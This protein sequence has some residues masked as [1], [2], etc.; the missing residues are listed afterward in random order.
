LHGF[1]Y[2]QETTGLTAK[3]KHQIVVIKANIHK[4][5]DSIEWPFIIQC[6]KASGF[7]ER[8]C[9]WIEFLIL[10]GTSKVILNSIAD[11]NINLKRGVRQGDPM[12]PFIFNIAIDFLARCITQ[13]SRL[14]LFKQPFQGCRPCLLYADDVLIFLEAEA[15]K[16]RY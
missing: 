10:Q 12:S 4:A 2:A 1:Y 16:S 14:Q 11:K 6:L 3:Q 9:N 7:S 8:I 15:Q 5:F 13:L